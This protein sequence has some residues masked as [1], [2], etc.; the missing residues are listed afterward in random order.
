MR[1]S[2]KVLDIYIA[3]LKWIEIWAQRKRYS[4]IWRNWAKMYVKPNDKSEEE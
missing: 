3:I 1:I 2:D 4:A